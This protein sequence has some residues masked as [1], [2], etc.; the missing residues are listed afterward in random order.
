MPRNV[1][2]GLGGH[3][4]VHGVPLEDDGAV[5]GFG[6]GQRGARA[7]DAPARDDEPHPRNASV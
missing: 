2:C 3:L 7:R 5:A 6:N 1:E 4:R